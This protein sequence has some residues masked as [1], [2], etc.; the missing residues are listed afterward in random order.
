MKRC[1][2]LLLLFALS[3]C[4]LAQD[5]R[6]KSTGATCAAF[7]CVVASVSLTNQ[8]QGIPATAIFTPAASGVFRIG[9]YLSTTTGTNQNATWE[10]FV[11]WT[12]DIGVR[13]GGFVF[14][15]PNIATSSTL[16]VQMVAGQPLLYQTKLYRTLG[17]SGGM[18]YNLNVVVEQ[19]Q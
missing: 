11:G 4:G 10:A 13:Q 1:L 18:T 9:T 14:A 2:T 12:D 17:G 7:P 15:L 5:A 8:G 19:L 3:L 6:E 16:V